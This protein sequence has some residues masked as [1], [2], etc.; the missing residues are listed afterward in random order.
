MTPRRSAWTCLALA[1][2]AGCS[3]SDADHLAQIGRKTM[4]RAGHLAGGDGGP[5]ASWQMVR[6]GLDDITLDSRVS[7]RLRWDKGLA[8][9]P[10]QVH[11]TGGVVELRGTVRDLNQR[12]RAV[13]LAENTIGVEKVVDALELSKP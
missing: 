4:G 5:A 12:R 3:R 7:A 1:C 9:T 6:A 11:T 13:D 10:I 2:L 8:D